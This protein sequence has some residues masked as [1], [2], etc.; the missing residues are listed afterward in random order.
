MTP[1]G[2]SRGH[3]RSSHLSSLPMAAQSPLCTVSARPPAASYGASE[4]QPCQR[5]ADRPAMRNVRP[6]D[7]HAVEK[8]ENSGRPV[9]EAAQRLAAAAADRLRTGEPARCQMFDAIEKKRQITCRNTLLIE[10]EDEEACGRV[11]Q[12]V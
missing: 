11:Q 1:C 12:E 8:C 2:R 7:P 5:I 10:R 3:S 6:P 9:D 4:M